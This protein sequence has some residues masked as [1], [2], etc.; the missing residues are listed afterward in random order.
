MSIYKVLPLILIKVQVENQFLLKSYHEWNTIYKPFQRNSEVLEVLAIACPIG[1][2]PQRI[3]WSVWAHT[4]VRFHMRILFY[5]KMR[6]TLIT[7]PFQLLWVFKTI[8]KISYAKGDTSVS[9]NTFKVP[10]KFNRKW[11][12][13]SS[14]YIALPYA[15]VNKSYWQGPLR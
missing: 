5:F 15:W 6:T 11:A 9:W 2:G 12:H 7:S 1:W 3:V 8:L 10:L 14:K 4:L 13:I